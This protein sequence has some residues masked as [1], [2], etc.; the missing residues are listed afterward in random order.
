MDESG[1]EWEKVTLCAFAQ[2]KDTKKKVDFLV[3]MDESRSDSATAAGK[4]CASTVGIDFS[5]VTTCSNGA[6][7]TSLLTAASKAFNDKLPGR[8]TIPHVFVNDIDTSP[9]YSAIKAELCKDGSTAAA[10]NQQAKK[11]C[12]V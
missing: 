6:Q 7:A 11:E 10:C 5:A 2:V 3:C 4:A 1:C 8:T 12:V 9:S